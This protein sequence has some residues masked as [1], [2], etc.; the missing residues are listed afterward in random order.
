VVI[1]RRVTLRVTPHAVTYALGV[2]LVASLYYGSAK[3]GYVMRFS[4]PVASI[5]WLPVGVAIAS[6]YLAGLRF[7]PGILIGD[8]WANDYSQLPIGSAFAQTVGNL[9]EVVIGVV[10]IRRLIRSGSPLKS[11][12]TLAR[13]LFALALATLVSATIG[14]TSTRLGGVVHG[15]AWL[16]IWRTWWLGDFC[17]ALI[18]VP[19]VLAWSTPPK[20]GWL[21]RPKMGS[22][23]GA[24]ALTAL[25]VLALR[26]QSPV[27]YLA[28][29]GLI[30][31]ALRFGSRGATLAIAFGAAL[32]IWNTTHFTGPFAFDSIT[33]RVL[34]TQLFLAVAAVSALCLVALVSEREDFA[35]RLGGSRNLLLHA[36]D[37][38]REQIERNLH[39]GAQQRLLALAV[40]LRL[41][42]RIP[43]TP[44]ETAA[45]L[46]GA[47]AELMAAIEELRELAHGTH[48]SVLTNLGLAPAINRIAAGSEIPVTL[49]E[50]PTRRLE[51]DV[52]LAAYFV[53][54]ESVTNAR[55]HAGAHHIDIRARLDHRKLFLE[56]ADDGVGGAEV[57]P[58][59]GLGGLR[60][61]V[62][63]IGGTFDVVSRPGA[64]TRVRAAIPVAS[65]T[66]A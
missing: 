14:S 7:L 65:S 34:D 23:I 11:I 40:H 15:S 37:V 16:D 20:E 27:T 10:L 4:G 52:E 44:A 43:G 8:L 56:I 51:A 53:V 62:E 50:L 12:N 42:A 25:A 39:D 19:L 17:G 21:R 3:L 28:F 66:A 24:V 13:L 58:A 64:G 35:E 31:A 46:N 45:I 22:V 2:V 32:T 63:Q 18:V 49:H 60:D 1:P 55:R 59:A 9:L 29:P 36:T 6:V 38:A 41:A 57:R 54:S 61:R 5:V 47:E 30:W 26:S 48:P 33:R